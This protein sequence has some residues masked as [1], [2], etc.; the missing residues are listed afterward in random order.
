MGADFA[1]DRG[2]ILAI[3]GPNGAGKSTLMRLLAGTVAPTSGSITLDGQQLSEIKLDERARQIAFVSQNEV[4]DGRL[5]VRDY[6][7]LGQMPIWHEYS[8]D[9]HKNALDQVLKLAQLEDKADFPI[10]C[11]S[12]GERQ[13]A[14][15]AR[16][17]AQRPRL[18]LLD[19]P[20]N[21]LDPEAKGRIL[22]LISTLGV[23]IIMILHDLV[24]IP[25]FA[26]HVALMKNGRVSQF[27]LT[28]DVLTS[29][30][31]RSTFGVDYL[32]LPHGSRCVPVLDIRKT[33]VPLGRNQ[34]K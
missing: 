4:P 25:E 34:D 9:D 16:A 26:S 32:L 2:A 30:A 14:H 31:V 7:E 13:R 5:Q 29:Q 27:G 24:L 21:H 23:T 33:P 11:L 28:D 18:L 22:S 17:L 12:G 19:E 3:A 1:L 8:R 15:I 10:A 20:T 6:V